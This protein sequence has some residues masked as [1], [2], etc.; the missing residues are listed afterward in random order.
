LK[1]I[2]VLSHNSALRRGR[3]KNVEVLLV[4]SPDGGGDLEK[5]WG[6]AHKGDEKWRFF[7]VK[8][9]F[10]STKVK[11]VFS[12]FAI[13]FFVLKFFNGDHSQLKPRFFKT[14]LMALQP[15]RQFFK[16]ILLQFKSLFV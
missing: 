11:I 4:G 3:W 15:K 2:S 12:Q 13:I 14:K 1:K 16:E 7:R 8:N 5:F 6:L 9:R 10:F